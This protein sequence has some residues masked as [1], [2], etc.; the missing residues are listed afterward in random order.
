MLE[1]QLEL[2]KNSDNPT[3]NLEEKNSW[4]YLCGSPQLQ[5]SVSLGYPC[6]NKYLQERIAWEYPGFV[7]HGAA[8]TADLFKKVDTPSPDAIA[9]VIYW[10]N[11]YIGIGIALGFDYGTTAEVIVVPNYLGKYTIIKDVKYSRKSYSD[12]IHWLISICRSDRHYT[13]GFLAGAIT[14][15]APLLIP[16]ITVIQYVFLISILFI[17]SLCLVNFFFD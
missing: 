9:Q 15:A 10:D 1:H 12:P 8:I 4:I 13:C 5:Q 2:S 7:W 16:Q 17:V 11:A 14:Y 3:H 6:E